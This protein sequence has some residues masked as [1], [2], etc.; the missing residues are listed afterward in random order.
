MTKC[1]FC[2]K[3]CKNK[4]CPAKKENEEQEKKEKENDSNND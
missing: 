2:D 3:P 4:W 1:D